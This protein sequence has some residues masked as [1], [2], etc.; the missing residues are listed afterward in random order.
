VY[1][2]RFAGEKNLPVLLQAF[3]R[4]GSPYHLLLVGGDHEA[5]PQTN[6]TLLP[7]RRDSRELAQVFA[8]ADALV[9]AGTKETFGLVILESMACGRP[10]VAV[11]AGAIPEFVDNSVGILA[12]P[13]NPAAMAEAIA[14]LYDRDLNELGAAARAR[15]LQRHTWDQAFHSQTM[16]YATLVGSRRP[17]VSAREVNELVTV[18]PHDQQYT[19][20]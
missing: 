13:D 20:E 2:G 7:F 4:L 11:N 1:A 10:V 6:V 18:S 12:P 19:A 8:S 3:A 5:R 16:A 9:H 14:A 17:A 15:V